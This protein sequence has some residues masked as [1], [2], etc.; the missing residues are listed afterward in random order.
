M[1]YTWGG[2]SKVADIQGANNLAKWNDTT[3]SKLPDSPNS[4]VFAL[5]I[6]KDELYFAGQFWNI[7]GMGSNRIA[8]W[9]GNNFN[10]VGTGVHGSLERVYSMAVYKNEL[11]IGGEFYYGGDTL[12]PYLVRW[13][14]TNWHSLP[15][16]PSTPVFS[17]FV[18][19]VKDVLYLG[20]GFHYI[21]TIP[22]RGLAQW[23]GTKF[24]SVGI[25]TGLNGITSM[26]MYRGE[27]I[28]GGYSTKGLS[29]DTVM[30]RWDGSQWHP[31]FGINNNVL[32]MKPYKDELYIGGDFDY[33]N[34][35]KVNRVA[36]WYSPPVSTVNV[37]NEHK[38]YLGDNIPNPFSET[39]VIPYCLPSDAHS[40]R[41]VIIDVFGREVS[42]YSVPLSEN[43]FEISNTG[44]STGIYFYKLFAD[45][46]LMDVKRMVVGR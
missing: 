10:S 41:L 39:T 7:G 21:D 44:F 25:P 35:L 31:F 15:G 36:K 32:C 16:Y 38:E 19:T 20:G 42:S 29:T 2:G 18:D 28:V 26:G 4:F 11:Y 24:S 12:S 40:A 9:D 43:A 17:L 30:S 13:D 22:V 23:D 8:R 33:I 5:E 27:L 1:N 46:R 6:Y 3:W 34:T 14:G 37:S 45:G